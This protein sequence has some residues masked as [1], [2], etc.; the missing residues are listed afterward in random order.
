[1]KR[2]SGEWSTNA[3][4]RVVSRWRA[5]DDPGEVFSK[6]IEWHLAG[7]AAPLVIDLPDLFDD[8]LA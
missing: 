4:A 3:E 1:M 6:R 5:L 2:C 8:A 7:M